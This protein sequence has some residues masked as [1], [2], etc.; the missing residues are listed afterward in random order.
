VNEHGV[1]TGVI[2]RVADNGQGLSADPGVSY[3]GNGWVLFDLVISNGAG[4]PP[5]SPRG[6][7]LTGKGESP[8]GASREG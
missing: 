7:T 5:F 4:P 2:D 1:P 8:A 3:R 6:A